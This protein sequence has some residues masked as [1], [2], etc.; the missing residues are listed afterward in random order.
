M[1]VSIPRKT[2]LYR[3][4]L[5]DLVFSV[6]S[7]NR[8]NLEKMLLLES[9]WKHFNLIEPSQTN[10]QQKNSQK[11]TQKSRNP[12][13]KYWGGA[14]PNN[15][16]SNQ[17]SPGK[18]NTLSLTQINLKKKKNAW[19]NL[20]YLGRGSQPPLNFCCG[21]MTKGEKIWVKTT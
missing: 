2:I 12:S 20:T 21:L 1:T 9:S 10:H 14:L 7:A 3:Y 19:G 13:S 11:Q 17:K 18:P 16:Q 5:S 8:T 15:A 6:V 4:I